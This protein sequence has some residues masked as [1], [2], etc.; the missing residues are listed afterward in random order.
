MTKAE[1]K[2]EPVGNLRRIAYNLGIVIL[3]DYT[4]KDILEAIMA[5]LGSPEENPVGWQRLE[6][7]KW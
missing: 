3:R 7:L 1:L 4:K 5:R 2:R 6:G